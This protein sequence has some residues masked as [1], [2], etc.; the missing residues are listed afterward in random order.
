MK[1]DLRNLVTAE[2]A[3]FADSTKYTATLTNL[4]FRVSNGVIPPTISAPGNGVWSAT[5]THTQLASPAE[6]AVA[7]NTGNPITPSD[8]SGAPRCK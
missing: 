6:C 2:E 1:S 3:F 7:I 4:K 8:S 5:I